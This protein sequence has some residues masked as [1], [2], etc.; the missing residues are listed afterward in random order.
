ML[1][2]DDGS[3]SSNFFLARIKS[4][5]TNIALSFFVV[6]LC[7]DM[8]FEWLM[9]STAC[10]DFSIAHEAMIILSI[11]GH[12]FNFFHYL[13]GLKDIY[14]C[15]VYWNVGVNLY[16]ILRKSQRGDSM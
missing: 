9:K 15:G 1:Y 8:S 13:Y 7:D 12:L 14:I 2:I 10:L 4:F 16:G 11:S 5:Y 3:F 6:L